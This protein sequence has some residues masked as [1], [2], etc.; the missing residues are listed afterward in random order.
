MPIPVVSFPDSVPSLQDRVRDAASVLAGGVVLVT[1]HV[2]GR[3]WG[4][5]ATACCTVSLD[6]PTVLVSLGAG[7]VLATSICERGRFGVSILSA[8]ALGLAAR[9]SR[10][11]RPKFLEDGLADGDGSLSPVARH[12]LAHLDCEL[13]EAVPI[14]DHVLCIGRV[15]EV[16]DGTSAHP[17][18]YFGRG[19]RRLAIDE[20]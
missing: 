20:T 17:L 18:V 7:T 14:A 15:T 2:D 11:G 16:I 3:P 9:H 6:P 19:Y 5:T 1:G 13:A 4:M 12:A 8:D 10:P